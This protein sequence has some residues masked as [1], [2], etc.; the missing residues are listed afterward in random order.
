M[1]FGKRQTWIRPEPEYRFLTEI[2]VNSCNKMSRGEPRRHHAH[3]SLR[4]PNHPRH[5]KDFAP[6]RFATS[7]LARDCASLQR[8]KTLRP[9]AGDSPR[10]LNRST[11]F[12][13][14]N[15]PKS[16]RADPQKSRHSAASRHA[17]CPTASRMRVRLLANP[18][19]LQRVVASS[20]S[21]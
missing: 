7:P 21:G 9:P 4:G 3:A 12:R 19:C 6:F 5:R 13:R 10:R 16:H 18:E 15:L 17:F 14:F 11:E 1:D 8:P 20:L 2:A